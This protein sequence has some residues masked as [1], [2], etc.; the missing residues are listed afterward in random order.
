MGSNFS[1]VFPN[2]LSR[3]LL[4]LI[5]LNENFIF[6]VM[7]MLNDIKISNMP[8]RVLEMRVMLVISGDISVKHSFLTCVCQT[9]DTCTMLNNF[10]NT[11][12]ILMKK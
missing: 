9:L 4:I 1:Y 3:D 2:T 6:M 7:L 11:V 10:K 8:N 12:F 5:S